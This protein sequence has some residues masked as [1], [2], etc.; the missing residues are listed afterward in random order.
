LRQQGLQHLFIRRRGG[1]ERQGE[2]LVVGPGEGQADG[3]QQITFEVGAEAVAQLLLQ[4]GGQFVIAAAGQQHFVRQAGRQ[5]RVF[6]ENGFAPADDIAN[7]RV[8]EVI[9]DVSLQLLPGF[10]LGVLQ[11]GC[12]KTCGPAF[13]FV[14]GAASDEV[15][16]QL[17]GID[18]ADGDGKKGSGYITAFWLIKSNLTPFC[19]M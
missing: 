9:L 14:D 11:D 17:F 19:Y 2:F 6:L 15:L 5:E 16:R 10:S 13:R 7:G 8:C 18:A 1:L 3:V 4:G 12:I